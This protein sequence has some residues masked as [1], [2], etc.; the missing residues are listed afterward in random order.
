MRIRTI[1]LIATPA[2]VLTVLFVS[3]YTGEVSGRSTPLQASL[4][5]SAYALDFDRVRSRGPNL[6]LRSAI[7]VNFDNGEV[8][9]AK[10]PDSV[11]PIASISKLV[12]A[13]VVLDSKV[14]LTTR[15]TISKED[16]YRSSRSHLAAGWQLRLID[17]LHASLMNSD[18]RATR[19]LACAVAGSLDSFAELMNRKV[20]EFG[21]K[22]TVFFEPTGLDPRNVST[23]HELAIILHHA[24][25]YDL[26]ARITSTQ[27]CRVAVLNR[28]RR[29]IQLV[30]TNRL[31]GSQFTVLTGKTGHINESAY[32]LAT[33]LK[34]NGGQ[35]LALVVLG[36]PGGRLRFKEARK[37]ASWG[38]QQL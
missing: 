24:C 7:L 31:V 37:L 5:G 26:I 19:T 10:E 13:M 9:F 14:G 22:N 20:R 15:A 27:K 23:A 25:Q 38:F 8:L 34:N 6:S 3:T 21:L 1:L 29:T 35:R 2:L 36:A 16:A 11:L 17:L 28:R 18:N 33:V 32:C 4:E 30:N 12:A